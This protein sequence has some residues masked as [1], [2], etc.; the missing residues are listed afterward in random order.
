VVRLRG[1]GTGVLGLLWQR[2]HAVSTT[3]NAAAPSWQLVHVDL[4]GRIDA[5]EWQVRQG[6]A[7]AVTLGA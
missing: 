3:E 2:R 6:S 4:S 1:R 7:F 5:G